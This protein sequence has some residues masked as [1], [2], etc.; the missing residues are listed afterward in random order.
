MPKENAD[1]YD[2][3]LLSHM[4]S[5]IENARDRLTVLTGLMRGH[6]IEKLY[7]AYSDAAVAAIGTLERFSLEG[8]D[9]LTATRRDML[10][11]DKEPT[12]R[13]PQGGP[14]SAP[15]SAPETATKTPKKKSAKQRG[16][17]RKKSA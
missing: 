5:R 2:E 9:Q 3:P 10:N 6:Q 8:H 12:R 4:L 16:P 1:W 13:L 11:P 14:E 15:D 7:L 17:S